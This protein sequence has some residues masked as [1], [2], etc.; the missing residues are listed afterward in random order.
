MQRNGDIPIFLFPMYYCRLAW[1]FR[2]HGC[3]TSS[4]E[5]FGR[6]WL[7]PF[8]IF[9]MLGKFEILR[10]IQ[11]DASGGVPYVRAEERDAEGA[12]AL[13]MSV[14]RSTKP[15]GQAHDNPAFVHN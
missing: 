1:A 6:S 13:E 10:Q 2:D 9:L 7:H 15:R 3:N 11:K 8:V 4:N 14:R 5:F 12:G